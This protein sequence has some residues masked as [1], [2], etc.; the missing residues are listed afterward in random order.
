MLVSK[1]GVSNFMS[2]RET[3]VE[4]RD[5]PWGQRHFLVRDPVGN[6]LDVVKQIAPASEYET[7]YT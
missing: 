2:H 1:V 6:L 3:I 4:L 5:E 7:S